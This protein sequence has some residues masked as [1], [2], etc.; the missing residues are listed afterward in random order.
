[1]ELHLHR[2]AMKSCNKMACEAKCLLEKILL[3]EIRL[4]KDEGS[5][6]QWSRRLPAGP[7]WKCVSE[8]GCPLGKENEGT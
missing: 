7:L 6:R 8:L 3:G 2:M 4:A 1:M 5:W